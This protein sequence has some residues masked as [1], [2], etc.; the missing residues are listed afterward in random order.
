MSITIENP[1]AEEIIVA[2]KSQI[3]A[4]EFE[5]LKELLSQK[6]EETAAEEESA[7]HAASAH[8]AARFFD[9]EEA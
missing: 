8:A 9:E 4:S 3:S 1:T 2:L 5:R 6:D 7:W